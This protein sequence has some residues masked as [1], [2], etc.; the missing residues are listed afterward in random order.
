MRISR[1]WRRGIAAAALAGAGGRGGRAEQ[2]AVAGLVLA[3][4]EPFGVLAVGESREAQ[5]GGGHAAGLQGVAQSRHQRL[6]DMLLPDNVSER[7]GT[8]SAVQGGSNCH[9]E[10]PT[11]PG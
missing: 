7:V 5:V 2:P 8:V 3:L 10:N 1:R 11:N 4:P 6:G 9:R